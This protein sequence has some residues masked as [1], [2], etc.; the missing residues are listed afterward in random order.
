M[1]FDEVLDRLPALFGHLDPFGVGAKSD[2][3]LEGL[4]AGG[5]GND[6]HGHAEPGVQVGG[7]DWLGHEV[8]D[9]GLHRLEKIA[10][11]V[12]TG[13][14]DKESVVAGPGLVLPNFL[15]EFESVD[16][17]HE[18]VA[19]DQAG[20]F[21]LKHPPCVGPVLGHPE[22]VAE[23]GELFFQEFLGNDIVVDEEDFGFCAHNSRQHPRTRPLSV[24][25][26]DRGLWVKKRGI[27]TKSGQG[28]WGAVRLILS[29]KP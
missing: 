14:E 21:L 24:A 20:R 3:F 25:R 13:H 19:D 26:G 1:V 5:S 23:V 11:P 29:K 16:V 18:P 28:S 2:N 15:A 9:P 10:L 22:G 27:G 17:G 6:A 8:V 7:L 12:V 4:D